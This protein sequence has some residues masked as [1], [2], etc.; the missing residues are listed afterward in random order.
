MNKTED[1]AVKVP[2]PTTEQIVPFMI[3]ALE[4]PE[5]EQEHAQ[6]ILTEWVDGKLTFPSWN[7]AKCFS[8]C[9]LQHTWSSCTCLSEC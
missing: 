3:K 9:V 5:S 7:C 1:T 6:Q 2:K 4:V 8:N